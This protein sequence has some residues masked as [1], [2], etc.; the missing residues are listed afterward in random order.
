MISPSS[1]KAEICAYFN[2][3]YI[4]A[5][6][7]KIAVALTFVYL[8]TATELNQLWK[9]PIFISHFIEHRQES[10]D[11]T[12]IDF[13]ALH[14]F[15]GDERDA[16]YARD[17]QLPF[18]DNSECMVGSISSIVPSPAHIDYKSNV[19]CLISF[20]PKTH[21]GKPSQRQT[22]IWQPPRLG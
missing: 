9:L 2:L 1:E 14:Y 21:D 19:L 20:A 17:E 11:I 10:P 18:R 8:F 6:K 15:S 4:C 13:V 3:S 16:D 7:R 22:S 12:L 5:V